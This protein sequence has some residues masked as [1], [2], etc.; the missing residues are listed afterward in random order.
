VGHCP[1]IARHEIGKLR[2]D[3]IEP[4]LDELAEI[5]ELGR[6]VENPRCNLS[7]MVEPEP[8]YLADRVLWPLT[9]QAEEWFATMGGSFAGEFGLC[10]VCYAA[11]HGRETGAFVPLY[12]MR[13]A[14]EA[15]RAWRAGCTAT[16]E[17]VAEA[18]ERLTG[19]APREESKRKPADADLGRIL[20]ELMAATGQ[21]PEY[22]LVRTSVHMLDVLRAV[23]RRE[24]AAVGQPA[25]APDESREA[26]RQMMLAIE[27]IRGRAGNG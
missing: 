3:G 13:A 14:M 26:L 27:A 10:A 21:P 16:I 6:R 22:W 4:T 9:L 18:A 24:A 8:L 1:D 19:H 17:E 20:A 5:I 7:P 11:Q 15:V 2:S 25:R 12:T 23:L